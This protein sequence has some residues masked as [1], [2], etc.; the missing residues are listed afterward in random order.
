M[1]E[2]LT[3]KSLFVSRYRQVLPRYSWYCGSTELDG[4]DTMKKYCGVT[5]VP[6]YRPTLLLTAMDQ[7]VSKNGFAVADSGS[8][9]PNV[10]TLLMDCLTAKSNGCKRRCCH[11]HTHTP[12]THSE[13]FWPNFS[14]NRSTTADTAPYAA[15]HRM[16]ISMRKSNAGVAKPRIRP[17]MPSLLISIYLHSDGAATRVTR[18]TSRLR[19]PSATV[20]GQR[21]V[22]EMSYDAFSLY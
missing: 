3:W 19:R 20:R 11:K 18:V 8:Q 4:S 13:S 14:W 1:T 17:F 2:V 5:M 7:S 21:A 15:N 12:H 22:S 6:W 16:T 9:A 10:G